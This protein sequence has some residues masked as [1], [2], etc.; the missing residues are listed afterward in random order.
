MILLLDTQLVLWAAGQPRRLSAV[1]RKLI[2]DPDNALVFSVASLWEITIKRAIGRDDF[3]VEPR[4]LRRSLLENGYRELAITGE[5]ALGVESLP[6]LH[7]D[8][9]DRLLVAQATAEG[10]TLLTHDR[11]VAA[12]PGPIRLV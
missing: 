7:R 4:V 8:L 2:G 1:A 10:I 5:H 6:A 12:Y 9:F 3:V 11:Q